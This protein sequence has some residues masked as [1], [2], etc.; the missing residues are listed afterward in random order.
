MDIHTLGSRLTVSY[1]YQQYEL[2]DLLKVLQIEALTFLDPE[3]QNLQY[4]IPILGHKVALGIFHV[5]CNFLCMDI[6]AY[7]TVKYLHSLE[8]SV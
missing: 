7:N 1:V 2:F 5:C 8:T 6:S 3:R 4:I